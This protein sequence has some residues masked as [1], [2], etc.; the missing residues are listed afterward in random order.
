M[1]YFLENVERLSQTFS[2]SSSMQVENSSI[3]SSIE[4][5]ID[6]PPSNYLEA[7]SQAP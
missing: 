4:R 2:R 7:I 6:E 5:F 1:Q 3:N